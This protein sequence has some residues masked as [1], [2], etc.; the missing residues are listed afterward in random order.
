VSGE[1]MKKETRQEVIY[2]LENAQTIIA[3]AV[4]EKYLQGKQVR[5]FE[6]SELEQEA[7]PELN[8]YDVFDAAIR[9]TLRPK[10]SCEAPELT[11]TDIIK[12]QPYQETGHYYDVYDTPFYINGKLWL[13]VDT[14]FPHFMVRKWK[15]DPE[16]LARLKKVFGTDPLR[17]RQGMDINYYDTLLI[18]FE[19]KEP[20]IITAYPISATIYRDSIIIEKTPEE[21]Q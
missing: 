17:W 11:L 5:D 7:I 2:E 18:Q 9:K 20:E 12:H 16:S 21:N 19:I 6:L 4:F 15:P 3:I 10:N 8:R 1:K 14:G 13:P